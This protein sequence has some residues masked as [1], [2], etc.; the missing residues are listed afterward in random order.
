MRV[1]H[2][3]GRRKTIDNP[4]AWSAKQECAA[5]L[6]AEG[7]MTQQAVADEVGVIRQTVSTW[8]KQPEYVAHIATIRAEIIERVKQT[9]IASKESRLLAMDGRWRDLNELRAELRRADPF[10]FDRELLREMRELEK[11]AA[12]EMADRA[13]GVTVEAGDVRIVVTYA[14]DQPDAS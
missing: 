6:L 12:A 7:S 10:T 1:V 2:V 13:A 14:N 8:L 9:G 11:Q 3:A 5:V 4:F